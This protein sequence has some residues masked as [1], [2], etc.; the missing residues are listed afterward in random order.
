MDTDLFQSSDS[1][2]SARPLR[3]ARSVTL[4]GPL[5][6]ENG[7]CLP[8]VTVAYET[9]GRLNEHRDNAVLI[10]HAISGD[11][12]VAQHDPQDDPGWW[13]IAVGPGKAIDT[14]RYFVICPNILGG[15][16]GTT[17]PNSTNPATGRPYGPDF[18]LITIG[19]IVEVQRRLL[20]HLGIGRLLAVVGGSLGGMMALDWA[21]RHPG[22]LAGTVALAT[23]HRLTSQALAFDVVGR[24]AILRD[25]SYQGGH[26]YDQ[27]PGPLVGLAIARMLG[28]ITYLSREAM[29][30]KF[31]AQR[32]S[33]RDVATQ[34]ETRF[35]VGSYLAYQGDRFGER[36]D[37]NSYVTLSMAMDLFDL[38]G[39][40][41]QLIESLRPS[42]CRWLVITYTSDWLF[43]PAHTRH[44]VEALLAENK[45]V[46]YCDVASSCGHDAFLLDN[47]IATYG[48][49][50]AGFLDN[51][52]GAGPA[53]S[54]SPEGLHHPTSIFHDR[55]RL[56]YDSI[57]TLIREGTTVLDLG[58]GRGGLLSY[59]RARGHTRLLGV[60]L[61][62][63]AVVACVRRG[64]NVLQA[65]LNRGLSAFADGQF[66]CVVLSQTLQTVIDVPRLI[67][68]MVRVGNRA[69]VSFPNLGYDKLR[70]QLAD[71][72][73]APVV[74]VGGGTRWFDTPSVR[75]LTLADF[76]EF[77]RDQGYRIHARVCLNTE[78][79]TVVTDDPNRNADLAI[80][81][82][83]R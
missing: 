21:V 57:A 34:F 61:D 31:D 1:V 35:S 23:S 49:L 77:C 76:E 75:F 25:P 74:A 24:N 38:G 52:N 41:A 73:R 8:S 64:L 20:D 9:Y 55:G 33:P 29:T 81:M 39:T 62:E 28:H 7:G 3:H 72:G 51:L 47:E 43:P 10:C 27:G 80:V 50:M 45:E 70:R 13:D 14:D 63:Q 59:L 18:P 5:A 11:S 79:D 68:E 36:F 2:R 40:R 54:A 56:D 26:Y 71:E 46:S 17:G 6:L 58:C 4:D 30:E 83:S 16:R 15:C 65:D 42:Q 82:L 37:A 67:R 60:E 22:R 44:I 19:D 32:L 78:T 12:H 48:S 53:S 69:V 66:D